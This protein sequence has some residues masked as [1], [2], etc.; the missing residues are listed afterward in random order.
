MM[1]EELDMC[2]YEWEEEPQK[3][4]RNMDKEAMMYK[5]NFKECQIYIYYQLEDIKSSLSTILE[6]IKSRGR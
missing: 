2:G 3:E 4:Q 6:V 5:M 1:N